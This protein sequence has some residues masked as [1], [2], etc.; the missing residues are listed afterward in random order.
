MQDV[1]KWI[2]KVIEQES[3][4]CR[5]CKME[6]GTNNLISIGVHE[7]SK[8]PHLDTLCIGML[9]TKCN[10]LIIFELKEMS[11]VDFAFEMLDQET[12]NKIDKKTK[13]DVVRDIIDDLEEGQIKRRKRK[14][15]KKSNI[16]DDEVNEIR[17]FLKQKDLS[18]ED[19]LMA[20]G[21]LP[22]EIDKYNYK[23]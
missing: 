7:S 23:K 3:L 4:V 1:P 11:L 15:V 14:K 12:A 8:P 17:L 6:F 21:M 9:C 5:K 13:K 2:I 10:E 19:F 16:T 20:L 22:E 18:H